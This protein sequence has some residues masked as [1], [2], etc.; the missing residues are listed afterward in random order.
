MATQLIADGTAA[1]TSAD[2]DVTT[3]PV[4]VML[5][6]TPANATL[7]TRTQTFI[8]MKDAAGN[9]IPVYTLYGS[10][11]A[12]QLAAPG[13]YRVRKQETTYAVGVDRSA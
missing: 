3:A 7:I 6:Y 4:T 10:E 5:S 8:D 1:A 9:Y 13:T 11:K 12:V 2:F